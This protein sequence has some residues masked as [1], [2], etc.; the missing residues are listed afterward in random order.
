MIPPCC[1]KFGQC[2]PRLEHIVKEH[3]DYLER[4]GLKGMPYLCGFCKAPFM[5]KDVLVKHQKKD[6]AIKKNGEA[7]ICGF[8]NYGAE[9]H[10][11]C[12]TAFLDHLASEHSID[13]IAFKCPGG[14][15]LGGKGK[16]TTCTKAF[17]ITTSLKKHLM[18]KR[19]HAMSKDDAEKALLDTQNQ[20]YPEIIEGSPT[21]ST[22][23]SHFCICAKYN[24]DVFKGFDRIDELQRHRTHCE[25]CVATMTKEELYSFECRRSCDRRFATRG[26]RRG[27]EER[28][29]RMATDADRS[30]ERSEKSRKKR[31]TSSSRTTSTIREPPVVDTDTDKIVV[32]IKFPSRKK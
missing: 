21:K 29:K 6:H 12:N 14:H 10:G 25:V 28:C 19:T 8:C 22:H 17:G 23:R 26:D 1:L 31:K 20:L 27:H 15:L 16:G 4:L 13:R 5:K 32:G 2:Y 30:S 9:K 7:F 3:S 24:P 11:V 18:R